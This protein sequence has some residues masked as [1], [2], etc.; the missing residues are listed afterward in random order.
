VTAYGTRRRR[1]KVEPQPYCRPCM[2]A[3]HRAWR[4]TDEG[5][6]KFAR[7]QRESRAR[8]PERHR[9]RQLLRA[10]LLRGDVRQGE[11]YA[12]GV[13]CAGVIEAH[14]GDYARPL[15]VTWTCRRH[16]RALDRQRQGAA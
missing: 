3:Y 10:A 7:E 11:C 14:H 1:G 9:A 8:Y 16:H 13:D 2:V 6:E 5:R 15:D 4:A 12:A